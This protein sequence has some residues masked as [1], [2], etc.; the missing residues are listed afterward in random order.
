MAAKLKRPLRGGEVGG[1]VLAVE[2]ALRSWGEGTGPEP[3]NVYEP[4]DVRRCQAFQSAEH[5]HPATGFVGQQ[6]L[7]KLWPYFDAYGKL[8]YRLFRPPTQPSIPALGPV[9]RGGKTILLHDLTHETGGIEQYAAFDDGF[10]AGAV[11]LAPEPLIVTRQSSARRRDG[12][13]NGKAFYATGASRIL[14]WYGHVEDAPPVGHRY[15]AGQA[16]TKVSANHEAPHLH[17]GMDFRPLTGVQL[18]HHTDYTHGAPLIGDQLAR[19]L[20]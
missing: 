11:V 9:V 7:D 5:I 19:L 12:R 3:D 13:P 15:V 10:T 2:R 18:L 20:T 16:I 17:V 8:R 1:D 6:T 4:V 14:Y